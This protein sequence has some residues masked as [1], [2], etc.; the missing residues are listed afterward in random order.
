[1]FKRQSDYYQYH[2]DLTLLD[3]NKINYNPI[4]TAILHKYTR[5]TIN[6]LYINY[7]VGDKELYYSNLEEYLGES[8]NNEH[9]ISMG[10]NKLT[11]HWNCKRCNYVFPV[12]LNDHPVLDEHQEIKLNDS[13]KPKPHVIVDETCFI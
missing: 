8:F 3:D 6:N 9:P 11:I 12:S 7:Y 13:N 2:K 1:M 4:N 5:E 10:S